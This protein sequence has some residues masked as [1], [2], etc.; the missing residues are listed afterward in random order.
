MKTW[1]IALVMVIAVGCA[2][3]VQSTDSSDTSLL[4]SASSVST[5]VSTTVVKTII[6]QTTTSQT[7]PSTIPGCEIFVDSICPPNGVDPRLACLPNCDGVDFTGMVAPGLYFSDFD[8]LDGANF[9]DSILKEAIFND[10]SPV[11]GAVFT[12]ADLSG[13]SFFSIFPVEASGVNL[14]DAYFYR[15]C[16]RGTNLRGANFTNA[17][18]Q[19]AS[20]VGANLTDVDFSGAKTIA[21]EDYD[22][23]GFYGVTFQ[24]ST[25]DGVIPSL[26][27]GPTQSGNSLEIFQFF[28]SMCE[29]Q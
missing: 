21:E 6:P 15:T 10:Q 7:P 24:S 17:F 27:F 2:E 12:N 26:N 20:F 1:L 8:S 13:S 16:F 18:L 22:G 3:G 14:A 25:V 28:G 5:V 29:E 11:N 19:A 23:E 4:A 9:T